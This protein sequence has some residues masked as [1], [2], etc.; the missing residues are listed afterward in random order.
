MTKARNA[1]NRAAYV[2]AALDV[3]GEV[4]V[5]KLS[6]R[7]VANRL[8]VSPMAM[9]K[10]FPA[11]D[12]LL[13]ASLEEFISRAN[14]VPDAGL[15][16]E[17]WVGRVAR[18][19]YEALCGE[20]TWVPLLGSLRVGSQAIAVTEAFVGKLCAAGFSVEQ[21]LHAY[22]AVIQVVVGAV[23]LRASLAARTGPRPGSLDAVVPPSG[24]GSARRKKMKAVSGELEVFLRRDQIE[25][26]LPLVI[27]ALRAQL[28]E[29]RI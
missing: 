21:A 7:N 1:L 28:K 18:G 29:T 3:I 15:P 17:Q 10:H 27:D 13:A 8:N 16:W 26:G 24:T 14:V 22:F 9:Y 12:D 4:G 20:L 23:C 5:D 25:I 6:M 2:A 11:K 19:M